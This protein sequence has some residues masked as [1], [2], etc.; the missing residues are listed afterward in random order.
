MDRGVPWD[1]NDGRVQSIVSEQSTDTIV[2]KKSLIHPS[3]GF[4]FLFT[5]K[6][7]TFFGRSLIKNMSLKMK[8]TV[9][10]IKK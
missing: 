7:S 2:F 4:K 5:F 9:L 10:Y 6:E 3:M 1:W 8:W